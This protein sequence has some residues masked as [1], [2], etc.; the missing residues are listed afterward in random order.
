MDDVGGPGAE[1]VPRPGPDLGMLLACL[2][3][4][5]AAALLGFT[6][7]GRAATSRGAVGARRALRPIFGSR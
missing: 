7:G 5:A 2:G 1:A 6:E 3:V 4:L